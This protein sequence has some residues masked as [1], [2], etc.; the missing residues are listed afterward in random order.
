MGCDGVSVHMRRAYVGGS[1]TAPTEAVAGPAL[2]DPMVRKH[3]PQCPIAL[4]VCVI[5]VGAFRETPAGDVGRTGILRCRGVC[6]PVCG[7][8]TWAVHEPPLR[9]RGRPGVVVCDVV[10]MPVCVVRTWAVH[11]P[12]LRRRCP[13]W[14]CAMP[15]CV[16]RFA[17]GVCVIPVGAVRET[18][19]GYVVC[20]PGVVR[21][22]G[23][24]MPICVVRTWAVRE[25]P[26]RRCWPARCCAI[27]WC[28]YAHL[29]RADVGGSR[30]APTEAMP[31]WCCAMP[32]C[33]ARSRCVYVSFP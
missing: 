16:C 10:C 11:E 20:R 14:R 22:R 19:A 4:R 9:R 12:P 13:A 18:P 33:N 17:V 15:W 6:M 31:A 21:C 8:R 5:P 32:R 24:F 28:M 23:V 7:A 1:R 30:T 26:L 27:L 25:P 2:C 3:P 29:R